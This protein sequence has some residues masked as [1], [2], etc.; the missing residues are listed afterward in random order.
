MEVYYRKNRGMVANE[1]LLGLR[2]CVK[3]LQSSDLGYVEMMLEY[4]SLFI[5]ATS[6]C[7]E[8]PISWLAQ[9]EW[10]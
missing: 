2:S 1:S 5:S 10:Y 6:F 4:P 9:S 7:Y 8:K 3:Q